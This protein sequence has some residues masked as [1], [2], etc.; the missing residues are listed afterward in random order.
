VDKYN[1]VIA[2]SLAVGQRRPQDNDERVVLFLKMH[3]GQ[4][5]N[6][7]LVD[8]IKSHIRKELSPR[9]VP[10]FILPITDIPVA[11][12]FFHLAHSLLVHHQWQEGGSGCEKDCLRS[13]RGSICHNCQ[14]RVSQVV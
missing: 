14:S 11:Q 3:S 6:Q 12:I 7:Q 4:E 9:H 5:F 2:D 10:A 13:D 1:K 8:Q